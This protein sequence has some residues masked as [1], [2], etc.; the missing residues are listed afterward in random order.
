MHIQSRRTKIGQ[1]LIGCLAIGAFLAS[2]GSDDDD[3][4]GGTSGP[5]ASVTTDGGGVTSSDAPGSSS[6]SSSAPSSSEAPAAQGGDVTYAF[7]TEPVGLDPVNAAVSAAVGGNSALAIYDSLMRLTPEDDVV[8]YLAESLE[9]DDAQTWTLKLR[10]GV[11]FTDGTPLD[12]D[13]VVFNFERH[14]NPELTAAST[15]RAYSSLLESVEAVDPLT[16]EITLTRPAA[17]FPLG[18]AEALGYIG[19]PTAIEADPEGFSTNPVGAGPY[20]FKEWVRD[21]HLTLVP[22]PNYWGDTKPQLDSLTYKPIP[23]GDTRYN[24]LLSGDVQIGWF[25]TAGHFSKA[26]ETDDVAED[27]SV[28]N[29]G[30]VLQI[31]VV[32]PPFDDVRVR[33]AV[34][35]ALNFDA[36]NATVFAGAA[37][38]RHGPFAPDS[39]YYVDLDLPEYDPEE[40]RRL[41]EEYEAETGTQVTL[42]WLSTTSPSG[43]Q[44]VQASEVFQQL[45][46][47]VGIDTTITQYDPAEW[48]SHLL[49]GTFQV[50]ASTYPHF[51]DPAEMAAHLGCQSPQNFKGYCSEEMQA[52]L[53]AGAA[54]T[55]RD[56]RVAAYAEAQQILAQDLPQVWFA[57]GPTGLILSPDLAGVD[58]AI[59]GYLYPASLH[60]TS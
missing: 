19:S 9:S 52:L 3:G 24:A 42:E 54:T 38:V 37:E 1:R 30:S 46:N 15:A 2:C 5:A 20:M 59:A 21:D 31:S 47:E 26:Q 60:F 39:P 29:G 28:G 34:A 56:A 40:G 23:D 7:I 51:S 45:M 8:P 10:D 18:L 48:F 44:G 41:I 35:H 55:D 43:A 22:N 53:D 57:S 11:M 25:Q 17:N 36:L 13:A 27:I 58:K 50:V 6:G 32:T 33:R 4:G 16:V 14:M 49:D 12:A